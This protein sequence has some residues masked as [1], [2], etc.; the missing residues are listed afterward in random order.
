M[1]IY[2]IHHAG[3]VFSAGED[4]ICTEFRQRLTVIL[5]KD[6]RICLKTAIRHFITPSLC[7]SRGLAGTGFGRKGQYPLML[8]TMHIYVN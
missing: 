1:L 7:K 8:F 4:G 6:T 2:L 3:N 5:P